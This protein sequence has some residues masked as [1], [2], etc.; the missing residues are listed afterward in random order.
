MIK[1]AQN[2]FAEVWIEN[3]IL[4][5]VYAPLENLSLKIAK[6]LLKLRLSI[7]NNKG[8]PILCDLR[9]VIQA[10]KEAMDYL[11]KEG[12][13]QATAV[14]LL[15]QY[16][17]TKSTAQFYLSTSIPKVDTEVFEDKLKALEFLSNYPVKN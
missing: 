11:A 5:F 1:R 12:S 13:V 3:D 16:P 6:N 7:Q 10:D 2:N 4:Y 8:Y 15:V 17:H 14:A 9:E